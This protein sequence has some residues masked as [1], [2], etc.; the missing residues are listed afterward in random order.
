MRFNK[1]TKASLDYTIDWTPYLEENE[2]TSSTWNIVTDTSNDDVPLAID[3][4]KQST[5]K[6]T[7]V[8]SGGRVGKEYTVE[9]IIQ[10]NKN[11]KNLQDR[12][13][14]LIRITE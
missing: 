3:K 14:L 8:L 6:T 12:R 5:V 2:I 11:D 4:T 1:S 13:I 9:N 7:V 10:Y